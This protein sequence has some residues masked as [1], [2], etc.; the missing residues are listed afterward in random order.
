MR[1]FYKMSFD[2]ISDQMVILDG[3]TKLVEEHLWDFPILFLSTDFSEISAKLRDDSVSNEKIEQTIKGMHLFFEFSLLPLAFE[4]DHRQWLLHWVERMEQIQVE[5]T[6]MAQEVFLPSQSDLTV[7]ARFCRYLA[8]NRQIAAKFA[9]MA[10][11]IKTET[12]YYIGGREFIPQLYAWETYDHAEPIKSCLMLGTDDMETALFLMIQRLAD[13]NIELRKCE[14]CGKYFRPFSVRT[15]YCDRLD[16]KTGKTCKEQAAKIKYEEKIAADA[17]RILYQRRTK[18]YS[19]R[20]AR[21]PAVY[22]K[23]DYLRW[24]TRAAEALEDYT[25]GKLTY[26]QLDHILTLPARKG[27]HEISLA[28][29]HAV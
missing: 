18:A 17:G 9:N 21:S 11:G 5:L 6:R 29:S 27:E 10:D 24:K 23:A 4:A 7:L 13:C 16:P 2:R 15:L 19:M 1:A 20:V 28:D 14:F 3:G 12:L 25:V 26:E 8:Q 22:R